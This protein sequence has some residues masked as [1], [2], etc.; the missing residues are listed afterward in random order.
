[1]VFHFPNRFSIFDTSQKESRVIFGS[2]LCNILICLFM[3]PY[4]R[5]SDFGPQ[6][7]LNLSESESPF[8]CTPFG[9]SPLGSNLCQCEL[10]NSNYDPKHVYEVNDLIS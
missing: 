1:M 7:N 10:W 6:M 4:R 5:K 8:V 2:H 9:E 3:L